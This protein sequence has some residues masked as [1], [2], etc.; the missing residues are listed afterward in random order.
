M[1]F[2]IGVIK[3]ILV[4]TSKVID[5]PSISKDSKI[6]NIRVLSK[7]MRSILYL[8][9]PY[10]K[11]KEFFQSQNIFYKELSKIFS[12]ER[13]K[14]VMFDTFTWIVKK[15]K[16]SLDD[17]S[18][19]QVALRQNMENNIILDSNIDKKLQICEQ[20]I[21]MAIS[22]LHT[23]ENYI[24]KNLTLGFKK[25]YQEA[26]E[27]LI[28]ALITRDI[29]DIHLFRKYAKYHMYQIQ[30]FPNQIKHP[31]KRIKDLDKLTSILGRIHDLALLKNYLQNNTNLTNSDILIFCIAKIQKKLIKKVLK[32]ARKIFKYSPKKLKLSKTS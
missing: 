5:N 10:L 30:L 1:K 2:T 13:E 7:K 11:N 8:I 27:D 16:L 6:H 4:L 17:T 9:K 14:K 23:F 31:K 20:S 26:Y 19:I 18:D 22:N 12:Q 32:S 29:E 24:P 25:T 28:F 15:C 3:N 21:L